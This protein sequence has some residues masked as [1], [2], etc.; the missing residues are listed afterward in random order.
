MQHTHMHTHTHTKYVLMLQ[1]D[2]YGI[3]V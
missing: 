3:A 2:L 1:N